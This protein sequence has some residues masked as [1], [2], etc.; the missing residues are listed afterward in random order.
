[1]I[2]KSTEEDHWRMGRMWSFALGRRACKSSHVALS[3]HQL[4]LLF[5]AATDMLSAHMALTTVTLA[6]VLLLFIGSLAGLICFTHMTHADI[7][8]T[9]CDWLSLANHLLPEHF[10]S[11]A[12]HLFPV[13]YG[14]VSVQKSDRLGFIVRV[15]VSSRV[16]AGW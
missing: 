11:F 12:V 1:V 4:S 14:I 8:C 9:I 10:T 7:C 13:V 16:L 2:A 6:V 15:R 3:Q 5:S